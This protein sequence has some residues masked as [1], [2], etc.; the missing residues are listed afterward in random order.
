[1]S[2]ILIF[3]LLISCSS[4]AYAG[5][6]ESSS[7]T[8]EGPNTSKN[9]LGASDTHSKNL[10]DIYSIPTNE[11][12]NLEILAVKD[13]EGRVKIPFDEVPAIAGKSEPT[14]AA[15]EKTSIDKVPAVPGF[16][17]AP[18]KRSVTRHTQSLKV[19]LQKAPSESTETAATSTT[20]TDDDL[21]DISTMG[22]TGD[23]SQSYGE[24]S[25]H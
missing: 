4:L 1:M 9:I 8:P 10:K 11:D 16:A 7:T 5:E 2:K 20:D 23:D 25:Y 18:S 15:D 17:V 3:F 22:L 6:E 21:W 24:Y 12:E 13:E 14:V 19:A